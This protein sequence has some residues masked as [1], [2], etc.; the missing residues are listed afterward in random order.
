MPEN[1]SRKLPEINLE[2]CSACGACG[3]VC[4]RGAV[5]AAGGLPVLNNPAGCTLCAAC[6][7]VCPTG[8]I[9]VPF[10]IV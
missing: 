2:L 4:E 8:A 1:T 6:E 7:D 3:A 9:S 5:E 10:K